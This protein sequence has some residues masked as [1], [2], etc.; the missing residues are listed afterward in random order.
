MIVEFIIA[1]IHSFYSLG[2][3]RAYLGRISG[4]EHDLDGTKLDNRQ[5]LTLMKP[6]AIVIHVK[7]KFHESFQRKEKI[8]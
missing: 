2:L 7:T 6:R 1:K 8:V 5:L 3:F 4:L